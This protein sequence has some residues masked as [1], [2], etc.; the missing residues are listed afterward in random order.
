L[1]PSGIC[2]QLEHDCLR[3]SPKGLS[4]FFDFSEKCIGEIVLQIWEIH[5][6]GLV[7][8]LES[9]GRR[10]LGFLENVGGQACLLWQTASALS[11]LKTPQFHY[12]RK[13]IAGQIY[14]TGYEALSLVLWLGLASGAIIIFYTSS[15]GSAFRSSEVSVRLL[16]LVAVK[17]VGP[18]L[19]ALVVI[20]RSGTA[21]ASEIGSMKVSGELES[22]RA[23]GIHPL[24]FVVLPRVVAGIVS[25]IGLVTFFAL[26]ALSAGYVVTFLYQ[27]MTLSFF[28][29]AL[30]GE[31]AFSDFLLLMAKAFGTGTIIFSSACY[32]GLRV[33][34]S[35]HEIPQATTRAVVSAIGGVLLWC[36]ALSIV[37]LNLVS[38]GSGMP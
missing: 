35:S 10:F 32:F 28:L 1:I 34:K 20:A 15:E 30:A 13:V 19:C 12:L 37:H 14:F 25:E 31:L 38:K 26:I 23:F 16:Y 2:I 8:H 5:S 3:E 24:S 21:V 11:G 36:V 4:L 9:L 22:L 27:P 7:R 6:F 29:S 17:E 18:L 33:E